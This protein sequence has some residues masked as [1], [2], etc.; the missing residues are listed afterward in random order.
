MNWKKNKMQLAVWALSLLPLIMAAVCYSGLPDRIPTNW[1]VDGRVTYGDKSTGGYPGIG[2]LWS[3]VYRPEKGELQKIP[4]ALSVF[5]DSHT[6]GDGSGDRDYSSGE[7]PAGKCG[8]V[9]DCGGY[10]RNAVYG[11]G[12]GNAEVPAEL[13]LR[14]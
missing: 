11:D 13:F 9:D 8:R 4:R 5:S 12:L 7:F 6:A 2:I 14:V 1:G 3:A 10:V